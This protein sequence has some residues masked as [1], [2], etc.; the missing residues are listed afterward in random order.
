MGIVERFG[1]A[2]I[3]EVELIVELIVGMAVDR[4]FDDDVWLFDGT[5]AD[6]ALVIEGAGGADDALLKT[7]GGGEG[8]GTEEELG[9]GNSDEAFTTKAGSMFAGDNDALLSIVGNRE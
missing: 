1:G 7:F 5:S 4:T 2:E 3:D 8:A 9:D 6:E